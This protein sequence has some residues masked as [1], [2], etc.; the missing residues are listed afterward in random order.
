MIISVVVIG[1]TIHGVEIKI[2]KI[3]IIENINTIAIV[4]SNICIL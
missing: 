2:N 3:I 1:I 4:I